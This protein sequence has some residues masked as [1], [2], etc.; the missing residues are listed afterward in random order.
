MP[1]EETEEYVRHRQRDPEE[2][3]KET[4]RTVVLSE[5]DGIKAVMGK[6]K[7]KHIMEVQ[8][9]LFEK[10]KGWTVEKAKEWLQ[11]HEQGK[12][13]VYALLPF[14]VNEKVLEKPLRIRGVAMTAGM[15]RN[16]N[17]YTPPPT[18]SKPSQANL[19]RLPFT[20]NT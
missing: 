15:S 13:H 8:S 3:Q 4:F 5:K 20:L 17:I 9:Y 18:N 14:T 7:G 6:P 2:F 12:E 10:S 1:W 16:F 11:K 19:S